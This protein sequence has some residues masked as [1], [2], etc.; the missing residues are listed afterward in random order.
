M[1]RRMLDKVQ[2]RIVLFPT[3]SLPSQI[4]RPPQQSAATSCATR[5]EGMPMFP[6]LDAL[7]ERRLVD[8]C[9]SRVE[10][11][12]TEMVARYA[13][14]LRH[15]LLVTLDAGKRDSGRVD[16]LLQDLWLALMNDQCRQLRKFDEH[17]GSLQV[18][19]IL[20]AREQA[21]RSWRQPRL[22]TYR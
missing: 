1:K 13:P 10:A 11:A 9:L 21:R 19:L 15:V 17:R 4:L 16:D 6:P 18:F 20:Q 7:A 2:R 22:V 5:L 8:R 12:W 14:I 3:R